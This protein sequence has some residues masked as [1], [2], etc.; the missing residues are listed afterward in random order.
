MK[1]K[2][3]ENI[4]VY[5]PTT[6]TLRHTALENKKALGK[7]IPLKSLTRKVKNRSGRNSRGVITMRHQGGGAK[8]I[9]RIIDFKRDKLDVPSVVNSI[10]YDPYRSARIALLHYADGEKRYII[11]PVGLGVGDKVLSGENV[12]VS[13][14]NAM[15][16]KN[17]FS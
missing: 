10:E 16:L 12:E 15:P 9:Y 11:A 13:V 7:N 6:P 4:K 8:R 17:I 14:G 5:N 2:S 1:R 3:N